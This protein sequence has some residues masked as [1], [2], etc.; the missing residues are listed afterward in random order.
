MK[1]LLVAIAALAMFASSAAYAADWNFYGNVRVWTFYNMEETNGTDAEADNLEWKLSPYSR[2]GA[3]IKV[4]DELSARFEYGSSSSVNLRLI[5]GEWNFGAGSLRIGQDW[6]PTFMGGSNQVWRGYALGGVGELG[7]YRAAQLKLIMGGFRL[8]LVE[9]S[10]DYAEV[11]GGIPTEGSTYGTEVKLPQIA[12]K[13]IFSGDNWSARVTGAYSTFEVNDDEDIDAWLLGAGADM[14]FGGLTL[15]ASAHTGQNL[16]NLGN[17]VES[18]D[19]TDYVTSLAKYDGTDVVDCDSLAFRIVAYYAIND[20]LGFEIGYG[21]A[22]NE[23]DETGAEDDEVT[24]YYVNMPITMAPGVILTP[25][26]GVVDYE[27]TGS[28]EI[29]YVGAHWRINF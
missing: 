20:M 1:K 15:Y 18:T 8:A 10:T 21:Y 24:S 3:N 9:P 19:V 6:A 25:E 2:I 17:A 12:A 26:I 4:S 23:F 27:E 16:G 11:V 7:G 13:Y 28:S 14:T 29:T 22:E 5:Y